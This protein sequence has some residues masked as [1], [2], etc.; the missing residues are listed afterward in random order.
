MS[1]LPD[2]YMIAGINGAGK[3]NASNILLPHYLQVIHFLN[4]DEIAKGLSPFQ[5]ESASI[6]AG[7]L[8]LDQ[9]NKMINQRKNFAFETTGAGLSHLKTLKKCK[10]AG[11][12][13]HLIYLHLDT[14]DI[15][16]Q[17][18]E[19]RVQQGG[20]NIPLSD[21]KR[22]Y[23]KSMKRIFKNYLPLA[24]TVKIIDNSVGELELIAS[25]QY[26]NDWI[27]SAPELW[28]NI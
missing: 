21:I 25:K 20:H 11:Y 22:R 3:T 7:R 24:D 13:T 19:N 12:N 5:P 1:E 18:V 17:R 2:V 15:A 28:N 8:M 6:E 4:A 14:V 16:I 27:I 23:L 26:D 10:D 9:I